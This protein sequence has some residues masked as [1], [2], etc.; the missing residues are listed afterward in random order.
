[1]IR[2]QLP[3]MRIQSKGTDWVRTKSEK[4]E[5]V[6]WRMINGHLTETTLN[7]K[8]YSLR[9]T[10][11][12]P[13][14]TPNPADAT[15]A[16]DMKTPETKSPAPTRQ[17]SAATPKK[18]QSPHPNIAYAQA[19][20]SLQERTDS[21]QLRNTQSTTS[22]PANDAMAE[23]ESDDELS[24]KPAPEPMMIEDPGPQKRSRSPPTTSTPSHSKHKTRRSPSPKIP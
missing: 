7:P 13:T 22:S 2:Q 20:R 4:E 11:S 12:M 16:V 5:I 19:L 3:S 14:H 18:S 8:F 21:Q 15:E 1:M 17:L 10:R 6:E 24:T 23:S 9:K